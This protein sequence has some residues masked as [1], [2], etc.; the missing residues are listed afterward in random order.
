[1]W[2][3]IGLILLVVAAFLFSGLMH[4]ARLQR[5]VLE[6]TLTVDQEHQAR[7]HAPAQGFMEVGVY[8]FLRGTQVTPSADAGLG[9][10]QLRYAVPVEYR[11]IDEQDRQVFAQQVRL[12]DADAVMNAIERDT[13]TAAGGALGFEHI[14]SPFAVPKA[15]QLRVAICV[16]SDSELDTSIDV[17]QLRIYHAQSLHS[18]R[19]I[20]GTM[21]MLLGFLM[22]IAGVVHAIIQLIQN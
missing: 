21:S 20:I 1:M 13:V 6:Q 11:V 12:S 4:H 22:V 7:V 16:K 17:A 18:Y 19:L 3:L 14:F 15:G 2:I 9:E 5:R 8:L 10:Y